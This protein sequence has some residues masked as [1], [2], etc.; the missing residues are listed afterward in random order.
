MMRHSSNTFV[1]P[2]V[3]LN[4]YY[5]GFFPMA[6]EG[7]EIGFYAYQTR[8]IVPLD[9]RFT[10]RKSLR[11]ILRREDYQITFDT[12][13]R[14]VLQGCSR[15]GEI[16]AYELWLSDELIEHYLSLFNLGRVHTVE[17]WRGGNLIGGLY[18]LTFGAAFC[19]ESMFSRA[20][21][22]SQIAL[23]HLVEH[24]RQRGYELLDA[25]QSTAHLRQFGLYECG[26]MEYLEAFHKAAAIG[27]NF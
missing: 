20:P 13:P 7:G 4:A 25:Q 19:G 8:G 18:G 5:Q 6:L 24:L 15:I 23:V 14:A 10:V 27:A 1:T 22:A 16:P 11:Q 2:E 12:E 17:V 9:D 21:Y 26:Q 3:I